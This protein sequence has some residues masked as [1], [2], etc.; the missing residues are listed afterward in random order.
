MRVRERVRVRARMRFRDRVRGR[1]RVRV[2]D[3]VRDRVRAR[4]R[5]VEAADG[6]G[7]LEDGHREG[8]VDEDAARLA[9]GEPDHQ[10]L[11]PRGAAGHLIS[12]RGRV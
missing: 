4:G 11:A 2:R 6:G 10:P 5:D 7:V 12:G 9:V 3:R 8:V 1:D